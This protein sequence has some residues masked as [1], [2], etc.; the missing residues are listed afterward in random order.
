MKSG[1]TKFVYMVLLAVNLLALLG[2]V[3]YLIKPIENLFWNTYGFLIL[4]TLVGNIISAG[5]GGRYRYFDYFYLIL[6]TIC[7]LLLPIINTLV[8][9]D[10]HNQSSQS[11]YGIIFICTLFLLGALSS[12]LRFADALRNTGSNQ[13]IGKRSPSGIIKQAIR[14]LIITLLSLILLIGF[15]LDYDLLTTNK[16]GIFEVFI[17]EYSLFFGVLFLSVSILIIRLRWRKKG[18]FYNRVIIAAG[19]ISFIICAIPLASTSFLLQ[20]SERSYEAAFGT[21][22]RDNT[23]INESS[24]FMNRPFS[25]QNYFLGSPSRDYILNENVLFYEGKDDLDKG[26]KLYFDAYMPPENSSGLPGGNSTLIRIH[27]GAWNIGDKGSS[28]YAQVNKYFASQGYVVFDIQ[29]GL[30]NKDKFVKYAI[31]PENVSGNFTIDDMMRHIG[32]FTTYLADHS[33]EYNAN[34]D[35]VFV[36]GGSAGGELTIATALGIS[37]GKYGDLLD[38]RLKIKG[39]IPFYPANGLARIGGN[40]EFVDPVAL[41]KKDS[42]PCLIYQGSHDGIVNPEIASAFQEAYLKNGNTACALL[43]MPFASHG[44]DFYYSS[45]YNQSFMFYMERFMYKF[46]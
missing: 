34:I 21:D 7:M 41:V 44:S 40:P 10:I 9:L 19:L 14:G 37:S 23:N 33:K 46:R 39:L 38:S 32:I 16:G 13:E 43:L 45:Y 8:S 22:Y 31:V 35:S 15:Y 6:T 17:P 29:Y 25:L 5:I 30:N 11:I 18:S 26:V 2:G 1:F 20:N 4:F 42:P 27:G 28:N 3:V 36:S 24:L 12:G